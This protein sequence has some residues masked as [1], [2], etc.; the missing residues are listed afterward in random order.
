MTIA[1]CFYGKN[2]ILQKLKTYIPLNAFTI[3]CCP[4]FLSNGPTLGTLHLLQAGVH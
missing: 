3:K 1:N 4:K 2:I